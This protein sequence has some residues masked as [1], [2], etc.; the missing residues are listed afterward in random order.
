M[1]PEAV[2]ARSVL[3]GFTGI[4][5]ALTLLTHV[6]QFSGI[7]FRHYAWL[8]L[9]TVAIL[10]PILARRVPGALRASGK[11]DP[12]AFTLL[13]AL[14]AAGALIPVAFTAYPTPDMYYYVPNAVWHL[15]HPDAPMDF[16]VHDLE[17]GGWHFSSYF[18]QV[19]LPFEYAQAV[20]AHF[21]GLEY[22]EVYSILTPL[23]VGPMIPL[24][25]HF[26]AE[27]FIGKHV[28]I[29]T[30]FAVAV[31]VLLGET[32]RTPGTLSFPYIHIGKVVALSVGVPLFAA[33]SL[34]YFR[35]PGRWWLLASIPTAM[36][37]C[38]ST[39]LF[40]FP[41]L[42][43]SLALAALASS[44]KMARRLPA[45]FSALAYLICYAIFMKFHLPH[46][47]DG[48]S[49]INQGFPETFLGQAKLLYEKSGPSTPLAVAGSTL[50]GL[51]FASENDR[52]FIAAWIAS[53]VLLFLNPVVAP[54]L[55]AH[56]T[57]PNAYWRMFYLYPLGLLLALTGAGLYAACERMS[58]SFRT[59][60]AGAACLILVAAHFP[61]FTTSALHL[62]T[63]GP[64]WPR[65]KASRDLL[66]ASRSLISALPPGSMLASPGVG[67]VVSMLSGNYP[68]L[69]IFEDQQMFFEQGKYDEADRRNCASLFLGSVFPYRNGERCRSPDAFEDFRQ[70][71]ERD[72]PR[73]LVGSKSVM[74]G[75]DVSGLLRRQGYV[76]RRDF[77]N[78]SAYW[79]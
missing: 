38:S 59:A 79:N 60:L 17:T 29:G 35:A 25:I 66:D 5:A 34:E 50:L 20:F 47:L 44:G 9:A 31:I 63:S 39:S 54:F 21:S 3:T 62:R 76:H 45:Y 14:C 1:R 72:R 64:G 6:A 53:L 37:G 52:A 4:L 12:A 68:Q 36:L 2:L 13:S 67:G 30:V 27:R 71:V 58:P 18:S 40:I 61:R 43:V 74:L 51:R 77:G 33:A 22:L 41:A 10:L 11:F 48:N 57:S 69:W 23:L 32:G 16:T 8:S 46:L 7:S 28:A 26:L 15:Q 65:I 19:S 70:V 24:A 56:V 75:A 73:Y 42:A 55:M 49:P 78:L